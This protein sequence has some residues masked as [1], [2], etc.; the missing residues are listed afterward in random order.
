MSDY[1][2]VKELFGCDVFN[3]SVMQ[4]RLPKKVYKELKK[5]IRRRK[6]A[7]HGDCRCSSSRDEGMGY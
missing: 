7:F 3:D 1:T 2:N 6:R 4:E 5:T